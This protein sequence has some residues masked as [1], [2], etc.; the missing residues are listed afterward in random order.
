MLA[1]RL[2]SKRGLKDL[3]ALSEPD[4]RALADPA[5]DARGGEHGP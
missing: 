1:R 4:I 5:V 3:Q 2:I